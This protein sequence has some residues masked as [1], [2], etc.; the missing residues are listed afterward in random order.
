MRKQRVRLP[1]LAW[2][3]DTEMEL[4][5]PSSWEVTVC[6]MK[7]YN[8]AR[9]SED[10]MRAA[11][12]RPIGTLPLKELARGKK[13]VAILFDDLSRPVRASELVPYVLEEMREAG[14]ADK[15]I[16]FIA[17][18]GA[19]AAMTRFDFA[20]KL[21]E[22]IVERFP[23]Y[24]HNI[25]EN[26]TYLGKTSRGTPVS[27][28]SE[29]VACDLKIAIGSCVPHPIA[30]FSSGGKL[31][32]PGI[33]SIE[34]I[35]ANH[36]NIG[37]LDRPTE[38]DPLIKTKPGMGMGKVEGNAMR[39]DAE[40]VARM[41]GLNFI[42]N[43]VLNLKREI[44]GLFVGD[45]VAAHREGVKLGQQVYVTEKVADMDIVVSNAYAKANEAF[46][47]IMPGAE[48]LRKEGGDL[49]II[50]NCPEGQVVHYLVGAF[51]KTVAG[52][53]PLQRLGLPLRVNRIFVLSA[54]IDRASTYWFGP[55]ESVIWLKT[56]EDVLESLT[57]SHPGRAKVAVIP[58]GTVQYF[59]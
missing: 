32:T 24:N 38:C 18:L 35:W 44:V 26:C 17:A 37:G 54:Y 27:L 50:A 8:K 3:K 13:E 30:G 56:W 33:A 2:H 59:E 7:G 15:S 43:P 25:Y 5:F 46:I 40:E 20:R 34:T 31:V 9:L 53:M 6:H 51:G 42:V 16:R 10:Q 23:V 12:A 41:L 28:N 45:M 4:H 21:G 49:V 29:V 39:L 57:V 58:D 22:D 1:Q 55:D 52:R 48:P 36:R 14:I 47:A 19:H 11:F